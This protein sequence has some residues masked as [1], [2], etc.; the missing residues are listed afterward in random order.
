MNKRQNEIDEYIGY[1]KEELVE[2]YNVSEEKAIFLI[3]EFQLQELFDRHG[4]IVSHY[5]PEEFAE[6]IYERNKQSK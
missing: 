3:K 5:S 1:V 4:S 6:T 2:N